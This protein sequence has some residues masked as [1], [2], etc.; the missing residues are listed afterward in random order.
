M[1]CDLLQTKLITTDGIIIILSFANFSLKITDMC[2]EDKH[3]AIKLNE[4]AWFNNNNNN[5]TR[6]PRNSMYTIKKYP[7]FAVHTPVGFSFFE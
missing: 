3:Y 4:K 5:L 6:G 1:L 2:I 7:Y